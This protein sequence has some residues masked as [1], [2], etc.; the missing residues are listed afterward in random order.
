MYLTFQVPVSRQH[1]REKASTPIRQNKY[2][3]KAHTPPDKRGASVKGNPTPDN[4]QAS[5]LSQYN[6][7]INN[8]PSL[9]SSD[10]SIASAIYGR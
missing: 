7:N 10:S 3:T 2:H 4:K 9:D 1:N 5:Q 6:N 8:P